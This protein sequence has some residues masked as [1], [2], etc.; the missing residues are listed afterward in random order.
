MVEQVA[1]AIRRGVGLGERD[2]TLPISCLAKKSGT[3]SFLMLQS[4]ASLQ[5]L[6][7]S[8]G[9]YDKDSSLLRCY[10][11]LLLEGLYCLH[12][13]ANISGS[14]V[15]LRLL[16]FMWSRGYPPFWGSENTESIADFMS[17]TAGRDNRSV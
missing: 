1:L 9:V 4:V 3:C 10:S 16:P 13:Q 17:K 7:F 6:R 12:P 2:A 14:M 15:G 8:Q 5:G 11:Y